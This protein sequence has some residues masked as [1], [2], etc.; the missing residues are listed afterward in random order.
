VVEDVAARA[1]VP[2]WIPPDVAGRCC[3]M[4]FASK[5]YD[6]ASRTALDRTVRALVSWT[7]DGRL[8][9]VVDSSP[10]ALT[11]RHAGPDLPP[12]ERRRFDRLQ[13][14]DAVEFMHDRLLPGLEIRRRRGPVVL[15]PVCS[16]VKGNLTGKLVRLAEA[17]SERADV[18][19]AAGCCGFAGDRGFGVPQ[20]T[21]SATRA[22]AAEIAG[23]TYDGFYS[24]SRTCEIGLARATGRPWSSI[25]YLLDEATRARC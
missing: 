25:W 9:V 12:S 8:P 14:L 15:H 10:C 1:G 21:A 3:G 13:I 5:G 17:C 6:R 19:L 11:L 20:L 7:E 4:P 23:R 22:E 24:T 18:P 2:V 16:L